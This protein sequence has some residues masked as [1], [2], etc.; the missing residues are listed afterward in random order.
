MESFYITLRLHKG[1][2]FP[3]GVRIV[4]PV[5][6]ALPDGPLIPIVCLDVLLFNVTVFTVRASAVVGDIQ[7][8]KFLERICSEPSSVVKKIN[9]TK[10]QK[11][12]AMLSREKRQPA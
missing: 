9:E 5:L 6:P 1:E 2:L 3:I 8:D 4:V 7:A 11:G 12:Q 10:R